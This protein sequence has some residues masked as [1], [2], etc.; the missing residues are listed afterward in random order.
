MNDQ[1]TFQAPVGVPSVSTVS[2]GTTTTSGGTTIA[3]TGNNFINVS[4]VSFGGTSA[5]SFTVNSSTSISAVTPM[6][7]SGQVD[8]QVTT[9]LGTSATSSGDQLI[10][11]TP[12]LPPAVTG[13]S[14]SSGPAAG[15][16]SITILGTNFTN[17]SGVN[18]GA[19]AAS[20]YVVNSSSSITAVVP[21]GTAGVVDI[22][23]TNT[24]GS[25]GSSSAGKYTY[26]S[27]A[28]TVNGLSATSGYATGGTPVAIIGTNMSS[29]TT[30][31][32]GTVPA[33][34]FMATSPTSITA[35]APAEAIGTVD[36]DRRAHV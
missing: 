12:V 28:P 27:S 29:V 33:T 34:S 3:I 13:L 31:F 36:V 17:V 25:S 23:V 7:L 9:S 1:Y 21:T 35:I 20:S 16:N 4:G 26:Q 24:A 32:F 30:V 19:T 18:F 8:V 15:G 22:T 10:F 5:A 11:T 2:P 14:T 6:H